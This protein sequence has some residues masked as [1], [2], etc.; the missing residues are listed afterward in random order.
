MHIYTQMAGDYYE[1]NDGL[2]RYEEEDVGL[3]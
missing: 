2:P 3:H 1:F